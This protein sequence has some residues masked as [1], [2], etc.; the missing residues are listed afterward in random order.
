M[1]AKL[2]EVFPDFSVT[3]IAPKTLYG[4][5]NA[6][7]VSF[8]GYR[9]GLLT[10]PEKPAPGLLPVAGVADLTAMKLAAIASRGSRKDFVDLWFL[11]QQG[12]TLE[13]SLNWFKKKYRITDI[14]HVIRALFYFDEAD[15]EPDLRMTRA[16]TWGEI[17]A[18]LRREAERLLA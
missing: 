18:F 3:Y 12:V 16:V 6:V 11:L 17:K 1:Q 9:Y 8:F 4:L 2:L 14:G 13:Q 7:Q 10:S 5:A 15:E